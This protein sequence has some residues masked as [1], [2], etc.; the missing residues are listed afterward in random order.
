MQYVAPPEMTSSTTVAETT[1]RPSLSI[2]I[3]QS[4]TSIAVTSIRSSLSSSI[5]QSTTGQAIGTSVATTH[6]TTLSPTPPSTTS[7]SEP[8]NIL[9]EKFNIELITVLVPSASGLIILIVICVVALV[10]VCVSRV[11]KDKKKKSDSVETND[12]TELTYNEA[13]VAPNCVRKT[14]NNSTQKCPPQPQPQQKNILGKATCDDSIDIPTGTNTAYDAT[15]YFMDHE[16]DV[17]VDR[18]PRGVRINIPLKDTDTVQCLHITPY[19]QSQVGEYSYVR[20]S[21][22]PRVRLIAATATEYDHLQAGKRQKPVHSVE[23]GTVH[24]L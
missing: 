19:A 6:T 11:K 2:S 12:A 22:L 7:T 24:E 20:D 16:Y 23:R 4:T 10:A 8:G 14:L 1:I 17:I 5:S 3:S 21:P 18:T 13:Y 9:H 15:G